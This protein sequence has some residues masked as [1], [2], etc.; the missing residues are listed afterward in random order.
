MIDICANLHNE[1]LRNRLPKILTKAYANGVN[2]IIATGTSLEASA[3]VSTLT[4]RF[5]RGNLPLLFCTAGIHPHS[6][7]KASADAMRRIS[8]LAESSNCVAVGECGLDYERDLS[9]RES[10]R[11]TFIMHIDIARKNNKPLFLHERGS[12]GD[13]LSILREHDFP[14]GI[15]HCFTGNID[16]AKAY[17]DAG[18]DIG[19]T[20]WITDD[21]RNQSLTEAVKY[22]PLD[23]IHVET[24]SP[25][26]TPHPLRKKQSDNEPSSLP[27]VIDRIARILSLET[28]ELEKIFDSNTKRF[29]MIESAFVCNKSRKNACS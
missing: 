4:D 2:A 21:R 16:A 20:G 19:I 11:R 10:Q 15:V 22:I 18:L 8:E 25:Y 27:L 9:D 28:N 17:L 23:R 3:F 24:D 14:K 7:S 1:R 5:P 26:L 6:S 29:F 13:F 12:H